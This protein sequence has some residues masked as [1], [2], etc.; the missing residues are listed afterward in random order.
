MDR[1]LIV[2]DDKNIGELIRRNLQLVGYSCVVCHDGQK[3]Q[4]LLESENFNLIIM[5]VMLPGPSGFELIQKCGDIPVIFVTAKGEL[6]D[7]I[8]GLS[9]GAE[10]Y[11]VKPF[12]MMELI[13]RVNVVLR[14]FRKE[15]VCFRLGGVEV[16]LGQRT[17]M[18]EGEEIPLT[19]QE[20]AL[21]EVL[22]EN[23][24]IALSRDKL[25]E[26]AWGYDYEGETKTVDVHIQR[27]RSKLGWGSYIRTVT[28]VGYRLEA[29]R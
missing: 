20:F 25:L 28:K 6:Q 2:E 27:L 9:L 11:L 1:I 12:E 18:Q 5:D 22:I 16:N 24:N 13:A 23:R 14:R 15:E 17:V 3:M 10:D 19:P 4:Q 21:L 8:Q 26:L 7:K 29:G